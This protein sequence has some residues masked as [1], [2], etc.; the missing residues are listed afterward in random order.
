MSPQPG[1]AR[2][3]PRPKIYLALV[4]I[5]DHDAIV[6]AHTVVRRVA[7]GRCR[8]EVAQNVLRFSERG[9]EKKDRPGERSFSKTKWVRFS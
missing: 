2:P 1:S 4:A 3:R 6:D 5:D 7:A 9:G 8:A